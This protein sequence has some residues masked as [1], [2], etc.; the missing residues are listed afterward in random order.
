MS[1]PQASPPRHDRGPGPATAGE[2]SSAR[3]AKR[4]GALLGLLA[5]SVVSGLFALVGAVI[6]FAGGSGLADS[7]VKDLVSRHP[8]VVGLPPGIGPDDLK[9]LAG[10]LWQGVID[11]RAGTLSARA[12]F[13]AFVAVCLL[14]SA[15][16]ARK[17]AATWSRVLIT[18]W[19]LVGLIPAFLIV[20]D[21]EPA[22]VTAVTWVALVSGVAAAVLCWLPGV[23]RYAKQ[24]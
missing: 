11:D 20:T 5:M 24:G 17:R 2:R 9:S 3:Q 19:G 21:Y 1:Y 18:V 16:F 6:V 23:R 8:D 13:A 7:N 15:F 22:S 10:P 14:L 12:G 4:P